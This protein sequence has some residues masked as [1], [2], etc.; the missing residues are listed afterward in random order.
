[1]L[2]R[3]CVACAITAASGCATSPAV[4]APSGPT[5][6]IEDVERFFQ[7]YDAAGGR[8]TAERLQREY[9][10]VGTAGLRHLARVRNVTGDRIAQ[11]VAARPELYT[12]AR[13]CLAE[14]ARVRPRLEVTLDELLELYPEAQTPPVTILVGRGKPMAIAGPGDGVQIAL[15]AICSKEAARFFDASVEDRFVKV[16]AH[17]YVHA[18]Q[19]PALANNEP[20][21]VLTVLERSLIEGIADFVGAMISGGVANVAVHASAEGRELEIETRFAADVDKTDLS[22]WLD[23]TTSE[24]VGQL[25]YWVGYRIAHAYYQHTPDKRAAIREMIQ[26]TDARAFLARSG[27]Y[28]GIRLQRPG[29]YGRV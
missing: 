25:G 23:N 8:P 21:I 12:N 26:M 3:T 2:M 6:Q 20:Q 1:V 28:P 4:Q 17:E 14:L 15:E 16:I 5:I 18:Q 29:P 13:S 22:D 27:W 9:I 19:A 10:D 24:S 7:V 11:A